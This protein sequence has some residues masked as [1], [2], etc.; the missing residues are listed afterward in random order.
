MTDA[1][2][3]VITL[4]GPSGV[5]KGTVARALASRHGW[6]LLDSG[7]LYRILAVSARDRGVSLED[8]AGLAAL[9]AR[10]KIAFSVDGADAERITVDDRDITELVRREESGGLASR[11]AE[12]PEVR[13][14]LFE[15][16]RAFRQAPGLVAD[17]RDMGTVVFTDAPLKV[18]LDASAE[19]RAHRRWRQLSPDRRPAKLDDLFAEISARDVRDRT[20]ATAPLV[21]AEDAVIIDTT[22]LSVEAVLARVEEEAIKRGLIP[23]A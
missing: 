4:D 21:P 23:A 17:G 2:P 12:L 19:E 22:R 15:R 1:T 3:A 5:G 20:R 7:A 14:A 6:H 8:A 9:A 11:I 10:L 18:F 13:T 16:Q